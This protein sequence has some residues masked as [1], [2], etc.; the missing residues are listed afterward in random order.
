[1]TTVP[2][3]HGYVNIER[4]RS[5]PYSHTPHEVSSH[6]AVA[7]A[8]DGTADPSVTSL[9]LLPLPPTG[10]AA[11]ELPTRYAVNALSASAFLG[12]ASDFCRHTTATCLSHYVNMHQPSN[13]LQHQVE[14]LE[15]AEVVEL[16]SS[17]RM[18]AM[19]VA[20]SPVLRRVLDCRT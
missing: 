15:A 10:I 13:V 5:C 19:Q 3:C 9:L 11:S 20:I 8:A 2:C 17:S 4:C 1:M 12:D 7:H 6:A 14:A 18:T 16:V